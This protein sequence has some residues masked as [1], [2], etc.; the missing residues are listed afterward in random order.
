MWRTCSPG[1]IRGAYFSL[2]ASTQIKIHTSHLGLLQ[3]R[4]IQREQKQRLG[5]PKKSFVDE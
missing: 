3:R 5:K 1:K 4:H 2:C